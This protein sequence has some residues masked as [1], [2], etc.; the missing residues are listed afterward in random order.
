MIIPYSQLPDIRK[1]NPN[2]IIVLGGGTFDLLHYGH[3]QYIK[4]L[5]EYG[6]LVVVGIKCDIEVA[7]EKGATRPIIPETDRLRMIDSIQGVDYV[8]LTPPNTGII[9]PIKNLKPDFY[10]TTN[11]RW[12]HLKKLNLT[13]V[14]IETPFSNIHHPS[15][16]AIIKHIIDTHS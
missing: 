13:E 1:Q 7:K 9:P 6:Q 2:K 11:S 12:E 8:Y 3:V 4:R 14:I 15:T 16:S 5:P 10:V